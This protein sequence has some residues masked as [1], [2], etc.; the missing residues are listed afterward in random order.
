M[1]RQYVS[2]D[3]LIN[4]DQK[5]K[6]YI[7]YALNQFINTIYP[8]GS[9]YISANNVSPEV[10]FGGQWEPIRDVFLL[11]SGDEY[12]AGETGGEASHTLTTDEM[13]SHNHKVKTDINNSEYNITWA[14]W[15]E[16]TTGYTQVGYETTASPNGTT[17]E[18]GGAAHNNMPP[19]LTVYMWKRIE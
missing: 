11:A 18:G 10:L 17:Y 15:T 7:D 8:V 3:R 2:Y 14:A 12:I 9:I 13:P 5:I 16:W 19:Y 4:Y 6:Q 1:N